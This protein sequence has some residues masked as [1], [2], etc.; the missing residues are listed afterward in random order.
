LRH[1]ARGGFEREPAADEQEGF[2]PMLKTIGQTPG[3]ESDKQRVAFRTEADT[4]GWRA[5][6]TCSQSE[7]ACAYRLKD[8][9]KRRNTMKSSTKDQAEGT[10]HK[11][12]GKVKEVAGEVETCHESN[13]FYIYNGEATK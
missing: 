5:G 9:G 4:E 10:F 8:E 6:L 11:V 1:G 12:K 13:I 7:N 3:R 2:P